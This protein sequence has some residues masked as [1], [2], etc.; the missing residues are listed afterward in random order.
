MNKYTKIAETLLIHPIGTKLS[1]PLDGISNTASSIN[2]VRRGINREL[3]TAKI[4]L[5]LASMQFTLHVELDPKSD[6]FQATC[7]IYL[8]QPVVP[9]FTIVS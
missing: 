9:T 6:N 5:G 1:L 3:R 2:A 4:L 8:S 7:L